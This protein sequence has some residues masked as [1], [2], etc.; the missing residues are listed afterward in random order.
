MTRAEERAQVRRLRKERNESG[1]KQFRAL[2]L[3]AGVGRLQ[4]ERPL[5]CSKGCTGRMCRDAL[6]CDAKGR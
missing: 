2:G 4:G 6:N 1:I 3:K 5:G